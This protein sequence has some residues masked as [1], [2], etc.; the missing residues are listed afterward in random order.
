MYKS[1]LTCIIIWEHFLSNEVLFKI[2][3][4]NEFPL[5][6]DIISLLSALKQP[7]FGNVL[8]LCYEGED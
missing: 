2:N 3:K 5:L 7:S 4:L 8:G 6:F 1:S